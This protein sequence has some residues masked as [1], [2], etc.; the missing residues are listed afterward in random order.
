MTDIYRSEIL[1][2]VMNQ[3]VDV[4]NLPTL[5]MR[6]VRP[7]PIVPSDESRFYRAADPSLLTTG[8]PGRD[9]IPLV[10]R[11]R[12]DDAPLAPDHEEDL[13]EPAAVGG[14]HPVRQAH[15]AAELRRAPAAAQGAAARG[16]REAADAQ[17]R[18]A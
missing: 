2:V 8:H 9:H 5:F 4:P 7:P 10:A 14:L 17:G 1:G 6:T 15:R 13:D 3:L 12:V 16:R 11:L 18:A